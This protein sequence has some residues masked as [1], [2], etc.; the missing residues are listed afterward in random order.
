M[1]PA[2][3]RNEIERLI[4]TLFSDGIAIDSNTPVSLS[5]HGNT[6]VSWSNEV[7]LSTLFDKTN[8]FDIYTETLKQ[9]WYSV[10]L[11]DGAILQFSY[12]FS[13]NTLK[14][15]RLSFQPCPITFDTSEL[16]DFSIEELLEVVSATEL[17][18]RI[19]LEGPL[20]F[21]YD[22]DSGELDHPASHLTISRTSCRVPV[23]SPLSVGHF[24]KFLFSHFYPKQ[25]T[26]S[27]NLRDWACS[28]WD[29]CLPDLEEDRLYVSWRRKA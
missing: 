13:G 17:R 24:V 3:I 12:T 4:H 26:N 29:R 15:H 16:A 7:S 5:S 9:R 23:S 18:D 11:F 22:L 20:R 1:T 10:I 19:R 2:Q 28:S 8:N 27:K 21:D 14:K 25:W 6:I